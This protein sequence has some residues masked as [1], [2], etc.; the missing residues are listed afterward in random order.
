MKVI[1]C[2]IYSGEA[3]LLKVRL[4]YLAE[5]V[6]LFII[7]EAKENFSGSV[8]KL[9][10][11]FKLEIEKRFPGKIHWVVLNFPNNLKNPWEREAYQRNH[12]QII[13][14]EGHK[15]DLILLSD[16]DEFP[17]SV[18]IGTSKMRYPSFSI[19]GQ[20]HYQYC[21]HS[22]NRNIW[23]GT[24]AFSLLNQNLTPQEL[25]LKSVK[26]WENV[27]NIVVDGGWHFSSFGS[28]KDKIEKFSHQELNTW[29]YKTKWFFS[30]MRNFGISVLG[31]QEIDWVDHEELP[32]HIPC[33][34]RHKAIQRKFLKPLITVLFKLIFR[35][36][37]KELSM[38]KDF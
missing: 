11:N 14:A 17:S 36:R 5:F 31:V 12:L 24:I 4:D 25:R 27:E 18:F 15:N 13:L 7:I 16:V 9:N 33:N 30:L 35:L 1:D 29:P 26:Y 21:V 38:P 23:H 32:I 3:D 8:R 34:Y 22:K 6:D 28:F 19:A 37:V 20:S 2:T 10:D